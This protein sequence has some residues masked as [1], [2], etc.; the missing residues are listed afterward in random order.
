MGNVTDGVDDKDS[1]VITAAKA[2]MLE[3]AE[4]VKASS[5]GTDN[6][7]STTDNQTLNGATNK[8]TLTKGT[9][10]YNDALSLIFT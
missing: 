3:T 6:V 8:F 2:Y 9:V 1:S 7:A 4:I 10:S 5:I